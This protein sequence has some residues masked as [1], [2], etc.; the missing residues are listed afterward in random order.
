MSLNNIKITKKIWF[1]VALAWLGLVFAIAFAVQ[2][3]HQHLMEERTQQV[4]S[5][6]ETALSIVEN[7]YERSQQ[8]ELTEAEAKTAALDAVRSIRYQNGEEYVFVYDWSG[9]CLALAPKPEWEGK[10]KLDLTDSDGKSLV[11][12][13][14]ATARAGGGTMT[15]SFPRA[16]STTPEEKVSWTAGFAPWQWA[17]GT[18]VYVS[19]VSEKAFENTLQL[20]GI[21]LAALL[22]SAIAA[23]LVLHGITAPLKNLTSTMTTL[24]G[25]NLDIQVPDTGR[26]DEIGAMAGAVQVFKEN[27]RDMERLRAE[28]A[29]AE[30]E[31]EAEHRRLM[32]NVADDFEG[33]VGGV[34]ATVSSAA[35][36]LQA[37]AERM[38]AIADRTGAQA[39]SVAAAAEQASAGI[40][41]VSAASEEL[42]SSIQEI[43]RQAT[44]SSAIAA[45]ATTKVDEANRQIDG[46][47][48]S[49]KEIDEVVKL[50]TDIA[51][52]T[53]LL[54][55]NATIE[56]ARAGDAG[57]GFA[58]VANE[59]KTLATQTGRATDDIAGRIRGV[60]SETQ[61]AVTAVQGIGAVVRQIAEISQSIAAAVEQQSAATREIAHNVEQTAHAAQDVTQTIQRVSAGAEDAGRASSDV[62][63]AAGDLA[64]NADTLTQEVN[65]F[66]ARVRQD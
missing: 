35:T 57:K 58:V 7:Y 60:Q 54:A 2:S 3:N 51:E 10:N 36:Q 49:A 21:A 65:R 17:I 5:V 26:R 1:P 33:A 27:A 63:G 11:A 32:L 45:D 25:G 15:Y 50:I 66:L 56:A 18:G 43:S 53:N 52:Q 22:V 9:V 23:Y 31:A 29:Q 14:A 62:Q 30:R 4:R 42:S 59:V 47:S 39:A 55:L 24:A 19:S 20:A 16:G 8:G 46:L 6:A 34:V 48:T 41:T 37:T 28:Q 40:Q 44:Q 64:G 12:E 13:A 61:S 38:A